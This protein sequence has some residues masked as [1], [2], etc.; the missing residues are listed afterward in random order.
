MHFDFTFVLLFLGFNYFCQT[1]QIITIT[2][3]QVKENPP[4]TN[5]GLVFFVMLVLSSRRAYQ[6]S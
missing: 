3:T 5:P 4:L 2:F 1:P 6:G